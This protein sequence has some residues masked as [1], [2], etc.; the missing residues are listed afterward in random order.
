MNSDYTAYEKMKTIIKEK[1][2][3]DVDGPCE[4]ERFQQSRVWERTE[5]KNK[6]SGQ[7]K[8]YQVDSEPDKSLYFDFTQLPL[9]WYVTNGK[10]FTPVF[11]EQPAY[12]IL[13]FLVK[14]EEIA[15]KAEK[16]K[17][18]HGPWWK[19]WWLKIWSPPFGKYL[20]AYQELIVEFERKNQIKNQ[21]DGFRKV[22]NLI[23]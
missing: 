8:F 2:N 17:I 4:P 20:S 21:G 11:C 18:D 15:T 16:D 14:K 5:E 13:R 6:K 3:L 1:W 7:L 22:D 10:G 9:S 12:H 23:K 19:K